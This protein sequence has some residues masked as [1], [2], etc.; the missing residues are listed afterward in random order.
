MTKN[1]FDLKNIIHEI[2]Y[3]TNQMPFL[4]NFIMDATL[5][6]NIRHYLTIHIMHENKNIQDSI[7]NILKIFIDEIN[8]KYNKNNIKFL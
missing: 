3:N 8:D 7:E 6:D 4:S 5:N 1:A 2:I